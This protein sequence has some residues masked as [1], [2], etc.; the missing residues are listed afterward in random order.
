MNTF[1]AGVQYNDFTGT[2]ATDV[3]DNV[4]LLDFL[5]QERLANDGDLLAGV[6]IAAGENSGRDVTKVSVVCY[7]HQATIF[8]PN[9]PK[10]RAVE[11][12]MTP[13]KALSFFKRFDLVMVRKGVRLNG[14]EVDGPHY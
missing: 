13:S 2:V 6:R 5:K 7:L 9:P 1:E 3:S 12:E 10:V 8:D 11:C 14:A 4:A